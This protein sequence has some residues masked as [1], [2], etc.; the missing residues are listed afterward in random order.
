MPKRRT[1]TADDW[2]RDWRMLADAGG[3]TTE[4][5]LMAAAM[6]I[7]NAPEL[8][9]DKALYWARETVVRHVMGK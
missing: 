2:M 3:T 7:I 4:A 5:Q 8:Y 6:A 1:T 9:S